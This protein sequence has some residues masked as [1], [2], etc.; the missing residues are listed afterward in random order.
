MNKRFSDEKN[1]SI[2]RDADADADAHV[3]NGPTS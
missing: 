3:K 2:L 1:I